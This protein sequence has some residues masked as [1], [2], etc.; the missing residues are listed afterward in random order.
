VGAL[1]L[2]YCGILY[3]DVLY[4]ALHHASPMTVLLGSLVNPGCTGQGCHCV[5]ATVTSCDC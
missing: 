3:S 4:A 1:L 2:G 5:A